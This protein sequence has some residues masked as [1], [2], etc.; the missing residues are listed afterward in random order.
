MRF[1]LTSLPH[2]CTTMAYEWCAYSSRVRRMSD[3]L[4][5]MG[6]QVYLYAGHESDAKCAEHV[7]IVNPEMWRVWY[8]SEDWRQNTFPSWDTTEPSWSYYNS[9][10][11]YEIR[12]RIAPGDIIL[13]TS[14]TSHEP[15]ARAFPDNIHV[16]WCIG[17]KG[18][19][20]K[21]RVFESNAWMH[22]V[23]GREVREWG[24]WTDAVIP[25]H[26]DAQLFK[27][28]ENPTRDYLL[29]MGR[30]IQSK[31]LT[32]AGQVAAK[33]GL[34]LLVAGQE[35]GMA[36]DRGLG[37]ANVSYLGMVSGDERIRLLQNAAALLCPT[38]YIEP[39][40]NVAA[41]AMLCGT[42]AITTDWGVFTESVSHNVSGFRC[43]DLSEFSQAVK[44]CTNGNGN[45]IRP[46]LVRHWATGR[47]SEE[48]VRPLWWRYLER[49]P[50]SWH[51]DHPAR[52]MPASL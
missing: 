40:C 9:T 7:P 42:P 11:T 50:R 31:G 20:S 4:T 36:T 47:Y 13:I 33:A 26:F 17:Y 25:P 52:W 10:T 22:H 16:E 44:R 39:G 48:A 37:D 19:F 23:Y 35:Y 28:V 38:F 2:T 3:L 41:E 27:P 8:G 43:R 18:V 32:V 30:R 12:K 51:D 5:S 15:I 49:L 21:R 46:E 45:G 29:F 1:H 6:H 34:P 14:G 24:Q